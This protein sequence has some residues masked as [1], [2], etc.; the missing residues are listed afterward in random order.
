MHDHVCL[1][2]YFTFKST[3]RIFYSLEFLLKSQS[4]SIFLYHL[5]G[6]NVMVVWCLYIDKHLSQ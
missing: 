1:L 5:A 6:E 4:N 2:H 3:F